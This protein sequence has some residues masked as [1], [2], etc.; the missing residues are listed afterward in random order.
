MEMSNNSTGNE[1]NK[2]NYIH[3]RHEAKKLYRIKKKSMD[4][5]INRIE[6]DFKNK[7]IRNFIKK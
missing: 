2:A 4:K 7:E 1:L 6:E 5:T 3:K